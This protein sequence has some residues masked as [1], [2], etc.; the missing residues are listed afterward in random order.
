LLAGTRK[1]VGHYCYLI[2]D[3]IDAQIKR[4]TH[5]KKLKF[6]P[7][8]ILDVAAG[9]VLV[10][11]LSGLLFF[12]IVESY[13]TLTKEAIQLMTT[14]DQVAKLLEI[15]VEKKKLPTSLLLLALFIPLILFGFAEYKPV[16]RIIKKARRSFFCW[17]D[18]MREHESH[19]RTIQYV[20]WAII[21]GFIVSLLAT[22]V[23]DWVLKRW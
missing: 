10:A 22:F 18:A 12:A 23:G 1:S 4:V 19:E 11:I 17:G 7:S 13:P 3:D 21:I 2:A 8:R 14:Q 9:L 15:T 5:G 6:L 16:T 20:K